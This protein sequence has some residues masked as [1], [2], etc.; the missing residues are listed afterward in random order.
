MNY[1]IANAFLDNFSYVLNNEGINTTSINWGVWN[2]TG[3]SGQ[4]IAKSNLES[5]GFKRINKNEGLKV[6]DYVLR[7]QN[8][9][10]IGVIPMDWRLFLS[11]YKL[12][13][14]EYYKNV[15]LDD[16]IIPQHSNICNNFSSTSGVN[17]LK[18]MV[19]SSI[20]EALGTDVDDISD[21]T[22]LIALGM[23]SLSAVSLK[24]AIYK[25]TKVNLSLNHLYQFKDFQEMLEYIAKEVQ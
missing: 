3:M 16:N 25:I 9:P 15:H 20:S 2:N 7:S 10:Q 5:S 23:D 4:S 24:H 8:L 13:E 1:A 14:I 11:K 18:L 12:K 6:L 22:N 19:K 17:E 21:T